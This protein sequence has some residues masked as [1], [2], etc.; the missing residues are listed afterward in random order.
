MKHLTLVRLCLV[1]FKGVASRTFCF[2]DKEATILGAN[3]S[4]KST[5]PDA[6]HWLLFGKNALGRED[7]SVKPLDALNAT[8]PMCDNE[9]EG[10]FLL[11][12]QSI[13]LKRVLHE[14]WEKK[15]GTIV[16]VM[17]GNETLYFVNNAPVKA[18]EYNKQVEQLIPCSL[19]KLLTS[20]LAFNALDWKERRRMVTEIVGDVTNEQVAGKK[21]EFTELLTVLNGKALS[22]FLI[23][24]AYLK[25]KLKTELDQIPSRVDECNLSK[26][27]PV[28]TSLVQVDLVNCENSIKKC[29]ELIKDASKVSEEFLQKKTVRGERIYAIK[30]RL[31]ELANAEIG[32]I[33]SQYA[34]QNEERHNLDTEIKNLEHSINGLNTSIKD[35]KSEVETTDHQMSLLREEYKVAFASKI[36]YDESKFLCP[37][38]SRSCV[39]IDVSA[40][41]DEM[42]ESFF[43]EK[44][45]KC[46]NINSRGL[47][48]KV[49]KA[50]LEVELKGLEDDLSLQKDILSSKMKE[51]QAIGPSPSEFEI[52]LQANKNIL[53]LPEFK[54]LESELTG[55]EKLQSESIPANAL[56]V[57]E[58]EK[59]RKQ[60]EERRDELKKQ[61][62][63]NDLIEKVNARVNE[64]KDRQ[65]DLSQ[66]VADLEKQE[67]CVQ[68]FENTKNRMVEERINERFTTLKFKLFRK[69]I[70]NDGIEPVC[71]CLI[72]GVPFPDANSA[73]RINAGLEIINLLCDHY[74]VSAPV[75]L[76][77]RESV[78][79]IVPTVSQLINLVVSPEHKELTFLN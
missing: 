1:N 79:E 39:E 8:S 9:V 48:L 68:D 78:S 13:V 25:K 63:V 32:R 67:F 34:K 21:K 57:G 51:F 30:N 66:Q 6:F 36:V 55:L 33:R 59:E 15:T 61:L 20:P 17:T 24:L 70:T 71:E 74:E 10:E 35:K 38:T 2:P 72:E 12:G 50:A 54:S 64:L 76:D 19:F 11:D 27:K 26:P 5:I 29:N 45:R 60:F 18:G 31:S 62:T 46:A 75:F 44:T 4:G 77:N 65:K 22:A 56:Q 7:F 23:E 40:Q 73:S 43:T 42:V 69:N 3:K 41:K 28:D 14:K 47:E 53:V 52:K 58:M 37:L 49:K 16:P